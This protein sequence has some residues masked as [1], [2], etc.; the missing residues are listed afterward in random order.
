MANENLKQRTK[1]FALRI[2]RLVEKLTGSRTSNVIANQILRSATSVAS[3]Y[4]ASCVAKSKRDFLN[5][6]KIVEEETDET[7]FWLELIEE[8]GIFSPEQ[9]HPIKSEAREI[10]A[11]IVASIK[12]ARNNEKKQIK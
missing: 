4:R 5:K 7:I 6:L 8:T 10:L 1:Q 2:I 11:I 3:N 12:T 9:L